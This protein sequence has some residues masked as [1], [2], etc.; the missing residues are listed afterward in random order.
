MVNRYDSIYHAERSKTTAELRAADAQ[1]GEFVA[2]AAQLGS[3]LAT[4]VRAVRRSLRRWRPADLPD[5]ARCRVRAARHRRPQTA[6]RWPRAHITGVP[7]EPENG[8]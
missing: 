7:R 3:T 6:D 4:P 1:I 2:Q 8:E 5:R